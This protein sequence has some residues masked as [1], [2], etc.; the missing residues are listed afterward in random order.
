LKDKSKSRDR[1][2]SNKSNLLTTNLDPIKE[3]K[4]KNVNEENPVKREKQEK[5]NNI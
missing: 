5:L 3:I 1:E 2:K 4:I